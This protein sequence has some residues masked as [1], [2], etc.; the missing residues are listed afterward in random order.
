MEEKCCPV[1]QWRCFQPR[2]LQSVRG[3]VLGMNPELILRVKLSVCKRGCVSYYWSEWAGG[4]EIPLK[5]EEQD[6]RKSDCV[7]T[8]QKGRLT[9]QTKAFDLFQG[10]CSQPVHVAVASLALEVKVATR[11][12]GW[13][14][15]G[16]D[17]K[18]TILLW[19]K[20]IVLILKSV[21]YYLSVYTH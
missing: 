13:S 6:G 15:S 8:K 2:P 4:T 10:R 12:R 19:F 21:V 16:N 11:T 14:W 9:Y 5:S 17:G 3:R 7:H 20:I 1:V 18:P